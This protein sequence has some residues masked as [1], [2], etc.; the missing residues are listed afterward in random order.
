MG[1]LRQRRLKTADNLSA[2]VSFIFAASG[3]DTVVKEDITKV[4]AISIADDLPTSRLASQ[5]PAGIGCA[6]RYVVYKNIS[7]EISR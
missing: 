4:M 2:A 6:K 1:R 7:T 5:L 3:R